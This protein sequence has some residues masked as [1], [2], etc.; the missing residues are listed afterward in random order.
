MKHLIFTLTTAAACV[1][2]CFGALPVGKLDRKDTVDFEKEVLPIF[3]ANCLACHNTTKAKADL[4]LETPQLILKGGDSGP[5]VVPGKSADSLLFKVCTHLEEPEM[6]PAG[7]KSG[8]KNLTPPEL[9]LLK[10]W[11]DQGAKGEVKGF[12]EIDWQP[13]AATFNPIYSVAL[14]DDGQYAACNRGNRIHIYHLPTEQ[15]VAELTD[16]R[17]VADKKYAGRK[18]AHHDMAYSLSFSPDGGT[19]V[20]GSFQEVKLWERR[21][22]TPALLA[23]GAR[24]ALSASGDGN[25]FAIGEGASVRVF[26]AVSRRELRTVSLPGGTVV[27]VSLAADGN[28]VAVAGS[29]QAIRV[30]SVSDG[31]LVTEIKSPAGLAAVTLFAGDDHV[32]AGGADG[33]LRTWKVAVAAKDQRVDKELKGHAGAITALAADA[34]VIVSGGEDK[35]VRS[36]DGSKGASLKKMDLGAPVVAIALSAGAKQVAAIGRD[37]T[38]ARIWSAA[39][40]KLIGELKGDFRLQAKVDEHKRF[41][42]FARG[43]I[44][45]YDGAV[46]TAEADLKKAE[47][48][49]KKANAERDKQAKDA[50]AKQKTLTT[51]EAAKKKADAEVTAAEKALADAKD[52]KAKAEAKKRV[53]AANKARDEADKQVAAARKPVVDFESAV[54][55]AKRAA[56]DV[57]REQRDL[58]KAKE[59]AAAARTLATKAKSDLDAASKA[60]ADSARVWRDVSI[61]ADGNL[62]ALLSDAGEAHV[63]HTGTAQG[64]EKHDLTG[65]AAMT[66]VGSELVTHAAKTALRSVAPEWRLARTIGSSTGPSPISGRV[67][68]VAFSPDG[69]L[70]A[71]GS[72]DPSR[73][74][75]L[76]LWNVADG[77]PLRE[78]YNAH[79]DV[80]LGVDFS[81]DGRWLAS[82]AA[83]KFAKIWQVS[84]GQRLFSFEGHT[85]HVLAVDLKPDLRTLISAGADGVVKVWNLVTGEASGTVKGYNKEITSVSFVGYTGE[86]LATTGESHVRLLNEKGSVRRNYPGT[87]D[88]VNA[89]AGTPDGAF[90]LAGGQDGVLRIWNGKD[91]K[92]IK[93]F[94]APVNELGARKQAAR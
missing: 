56:A 82:G 49:L 85:H 14:T 21:V 18:V 93:S 81:R 80:V 17:I 7:N 15:L 30:W 60:V 59:E 9:A 47:E 53:E 79:S 32:A 41:E 57:E 19:L 58:A 29:D 75:Q 6:P 54:A 31:A 37:S 34:S 26:D 90:V 20:S 11:I 69:S 77:K 76:M 51:A 92:L 3:R 27:D 52:D 39:D 87:S 83:D 23:G 66:F 62:L 91:G 10:L 35:T 46:K 94:P 24:P 5:S 86:F 68:A 63:F 8:A 64:L 16:P 73:T 4:N 40:G 44:G 55:Q 45:Y 25:R 88:F 71:T 50:P 43:D 72:G 28:S 1:T 65:A 61:S 12:V 89:A 48:E 67:Y 13:L 78:I 2:N 70:L 74:G 22:T 84:N 42:A 33:V 38:T 36:W